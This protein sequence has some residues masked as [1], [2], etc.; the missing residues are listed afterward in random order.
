MDTLFPL[1]HLLPA[2]DPVPV[3]AA[4]ATLS[5]L[6]LLGAWD[7]L[8]ELALF[9]DAVEAYRLLPATLVAPAALAI[10]LAE[11]LAGAL[12]LAGPLRAAGALLA[13]ALLAV[14]SGAVALNLARGHT[15]I[16]C[17]CGGIATGRHQPLSAGLLARNAVLALL[18]LVAAAPGNGRALLWLDAAAVGC[19]TLFGFGLYHLA[20]LLLS[21]HATLAALR[22]DGHS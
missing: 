20:N 5:V 6:L 15:A 8:R 13:L 18:A 7:K 22:R 4:A 21:Q 12:L 3:H 11:A 9:R 19:F 16:D 14:V 10:A 17:G 2:L 1:T